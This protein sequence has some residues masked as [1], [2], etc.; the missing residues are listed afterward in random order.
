MNG[1]NCQGRNI[2][3]VLITEVILQT[4]FYVRRMFNLIQYLMKSKG[5]IDVMLSSEPMTA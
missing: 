3:N 4:H 1:Y 5:S 2:G